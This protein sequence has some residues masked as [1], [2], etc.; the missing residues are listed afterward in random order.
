MKLTTLFLLY[1]PTEF[2]LPVRQLSFLFLFLLLLLRCF[3]R[4]PRSASL[5]AFRLPY[6]LADCFALYFFG[7]DDA[8]TA[9]YQY[10][11][12]KPPGDRRGRSRL[13]LPNENLHDG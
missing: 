3:Y 11:V 4:S 10:Q 2:Q 1:Y 13:L 12:K 8:T 5:P 7:I 6:P 9:E